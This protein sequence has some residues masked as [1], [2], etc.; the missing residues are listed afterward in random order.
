MAGIKDTKIIK[1][2]PHLLTYI[3]PNEV[4]KLKALGGQET[5]TPEGI[6]AYPEFDNYTESSLAGTSSAGSGLTRSEFEGGAYS[7]TGNA[8]QALASANLI[9]TQQAAAKKVREEKER[10]ALKKQLESGPVNRNPYADFFSK[11]KIK[12]MNKAARRNKY[13]TLQEL[14]QLPKDELSKSQLAFMA[15]NPLYGFGKLI[16]GQTKVNPETD[17]FDI[18]SIREIGSQTQYTPT[19]DPVTGKTT[20]GTTANQAKQLG[21]LKQDIDMS[22]RKDI[23]QNEF[24]E[25]MN[26]KKIPTFEGGGNPYI[27]PQY[28]MMGADMG[29][30]D[31]EPYNQFTYD[32]NAFGPGGQSADVRLGTYNFNQGGR[33][34][35]AEGGIMELRARRAFGGIMDRVT[36]RKAYGLGSIFK[37]VG[38]AAKK[39]LSSDIGKMAIAGAAIYY[40][41]G[42]TFKPGGSS[43]FSWGL[44]NT[45]AGKGFFSKGNPLLFSTK[46]IKG[47]DTQVF[48]PWKMAGLI[49]AGGAL[50]GP[51]KVDQMPGGGGRGGHLID[52]LTGKESRDGGPSMRENIEL[53]KLEAGD[54]PDKLAAI[55]AKYNHML[56]LQY[57]ANLPG[58]TPYVNYRSYGAANGGRIGKAEGGLMD[59]GGMEKDYRAEGGFVPIGAKEKA[60][61]VPARLSVNEFV[62]TA[63]AV[64][65]AGGGDIDK[66]AEIMENMMVN[67]E[68]GGTVSEES[69]G[70]AGAQQMFNTSQRLGEVI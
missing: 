62:F 61:D 47:V 35:K 4:E 69:Q 40:G 63:D 46:N 16:S 48:N 36:G 43:T 28:A 67:L 19:V 39:V 8:G 24:D 31:A 13:K 26:R 11:Q 9:N 14:N 29:S 21:Y 68:K 5:M 22:T 52:P 7:G 33:A 18:D 20:Y 38:K 65:G 15:M 32:E 44:G 57:H 3:T 66:G 49:T 58:A 70:N 34:K 56:N 30:E 54:D 2:Q 64:R 50:A 17:M 42:G 60:D 23:T 45:P 1:G 12:S 6:P 41:G 59:L 51:A 37:K 55:D 10:Q 27:L 25:Y 53:A